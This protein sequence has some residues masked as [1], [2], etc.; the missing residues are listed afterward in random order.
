MDKNDFK[1]LV[2]LI[3]R[4]SI[5][6][7]E[8]VD[9]L[10]KL[11]AHAQWVERRGRCRSDIEDFIVELKNKT[12]Y[13]FY[14]EECLW[15]CGW[16]GDNNGCYTTYKLGS[17]LNGFGIVQKDSEEEL[18]AAFPLIHDKVDLLMRNLE[19]TKKIEC[20]LLNCG[21]SDNE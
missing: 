16:K 15:A 13:N 6:F 5:S 19:V 3:R 14:Y 20:K 11:Y 4:E 10:E 17:T 2:Y 21:D 18:I 9:E 7:D 1:D 8:A 12:G